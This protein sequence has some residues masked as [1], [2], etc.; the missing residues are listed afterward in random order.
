MKL[1][2]KLSPNSRCRKRTNT[3][4]K[5]P[6][7]TVSVYHATNWSSI[8]RKLVQKNPEYLSATENVTENMNYEKQVNF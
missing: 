1:R 4:Y 6:R 5:K 7:N 8:F 2:T 3:G